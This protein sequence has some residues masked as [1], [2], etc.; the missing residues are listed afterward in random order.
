MGQSEE[1]VQGAAVKPP[2]LGREDEEIKNK[3]SNKP[4]S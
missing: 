4:S 2:F 1:L 3:I